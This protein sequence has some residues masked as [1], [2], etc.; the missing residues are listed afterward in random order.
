MAGPCVAVKGVPVLPDLSRKMQASMAENTCS[1]AEAAAARGESALSFAILILVLHGFQVEK[2]QGYFL[3]VFV[4]LQAH[5]M[6]SS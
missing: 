3:R 2:S 5:A 6:S 4:V 1:A